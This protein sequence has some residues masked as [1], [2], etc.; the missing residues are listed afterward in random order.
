MARPILPNINGMKAPGLAP[1]PIGQHPNGRPIGHVVL[2]RMAVA[3][4]IPSI[5]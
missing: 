1:G 2:G 3:I 4:S 5:S